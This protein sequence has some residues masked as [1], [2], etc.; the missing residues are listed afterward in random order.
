MLKTIGMPIMILINATD[1]LLERTKEIKHV[2]DELNALRTFVISHTE[3]NVIVTELRDNIHKFR[4]HKENLEL[5]LATLGLNKLAPS[6][7]S[8]T[9]LQNTLFTIQNGLPRNLQLPVDPT[10]DLFHYYKY[11]SCR[12]FVPIYFPPQLWFHSLM[13]AQ[14]SIS[15]SLQFNHSRHIFK[16]ICVICNRIKIHSHI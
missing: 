10:G 3:L 9:K 8:P 4:S 13:Q 2:K 1:Y 15:L 7:I 6:V 5:T 11:L 16:S 14:N 12:S